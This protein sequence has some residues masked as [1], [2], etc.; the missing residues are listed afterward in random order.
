MPADA[1]ASARSARLGLELRRIRKELG[2][3]LEQA[4]VKIKRSVSSISRIENGQVQLPER[5]LPPI[6][7]AYGVSDPRQREALLALAR[8]PGH[9]RWWRAYGDVL[10]AYP[11]FISLENDATSIR[12]FQ[13]LFI[14]GLLQT[15]SYAHE[16]FAAFPNARSA[17]KR[18][19]DVRMTRQL[20]LDREDP[21]DYHAII[22]EGALHQL[23]GGPKVMR[24]QLLHLPEAATRPHVKLQVLPFSAGAHVG[25]G[26]FTL[27]AVPAF[28][29]D[30]VSTDSLAGRA[31]WDEAKVTRRYSLV[32]DGLYDSALP[33]TES[34]EL[35]VH[36]AERWNSEP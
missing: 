28:D 33:E 21:P 30:V 12:T 31:V 27:L 11:D 34:L 5:D 3:T 22:A 29:S 6:L 10:T 2:L 32:F 1:S 36:L 24:D 20:I 25:P 23:A 14:P 7:D 35:I 13:T 26:S 16:L 9:A 18:L 15:R 4:H 19:T 8:G 17:I